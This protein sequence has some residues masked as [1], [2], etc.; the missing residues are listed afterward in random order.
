MSIRQSPA[1]L[2]ADIHEHTTYAKGLTDPQNQPAENSAS[3]FAPAG[4]EMLSCK[5]Q[6]EMSTT[7]S[8]P[9]GH[10]QQQHIAVI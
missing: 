6:R 9:V 1:A 4:I 2:H 3:K 7:T 5:M 8:C 10:Y